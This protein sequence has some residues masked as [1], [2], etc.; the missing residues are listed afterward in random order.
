MRQ[1]DQRNQ[2][3]ASTCRGRLRISYWVRFLTLRLA[4]LLRILV[5]E[6]YDLSI[7]PRP[8]IHM[9]LTKDGCGRCVEL[10]EAANGSKGAR[11]QQRGLRPTEVNGISICASVAFRDCRS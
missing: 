1:I 5:I 2:A 11:C 8:D 6:E 9:S 3:G 7:I 10:F 4:L